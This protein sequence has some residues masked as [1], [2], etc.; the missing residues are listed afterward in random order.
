[1]ARVVF[2]GTPQFA[3]PALEA[4]DEHHQ[5]VGVVTQPDRRAGRGRRLLGS[6]VKEEAQARGLPLYQPETLGTTEAVE[7]L[8]GWQPEMM[9]VAAFG[10][11][12][13]APVLE[14]PPCGCLN[15][16]PSLLP[17]YR[18][19]AP[20]SAAILAGEPASGVT[21]ML[22]D[23]GMDTGPILAQTKCPLGPDDTT[24]SLTAMLAET[25]AQLLIET[26]PGWLAG[27]IEPQPQDDSSATYCYPLS[28][29]DGRLDWTRPALTLGRQVRACDPWPGAYTTW[30]GIRLKVLAARPRPEWHGT[31]DPG[32]VIALDPGVGVVTG[33][34]VLELVDL[35]LAGKKA[36]AADL[37]ARGQRG[38]IDGSLGP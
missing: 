15:V 12:L 38:F 1:V 4:L 17:R 34:G 7:H 26:I 31:G 9:V 32:Q 24:A 16:H 18:G 30:Q 13:R 14:L 27:E 21:I 20:V 2:M 37:F 10:Q 6:P 29:A 8:A 25:G 19:A 28:K 23:E 3:V 11:I 5:V 33:T 22:M 35:Q 36:M